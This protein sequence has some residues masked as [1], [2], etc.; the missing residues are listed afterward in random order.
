MTTY[1]LPTRP[2]TLVDSVNRMAA[3]TGSV[4]YAQMASDADYNGHHV[5]F[6][7]PN[8][9]KPYWTCHYHWGEIVT[10][11]R[12]DLD[13]CLAAAER[14]Y[15]R[16]AKAASAT[17][18]VES[19]EDIAVVEARGRWELYSQ[20]AEEAH[21]ATFKDE[22]YDLLSEAVSY[23]KHGLWMGAVG[24]L[25]NCESASE[26]VE[27]REAYFAERRA[28]AE[29]D[30]QAEAERQ[31]QEDA[32]LAVLEE[33]EAAEIAEK[34]RLPVTECWFTRTRCELKGGKV[35]QFG[36]VFAQSARGFTYQLTQDGNTTVEAHNLRQLCRKVEKA[37]KIDPKHWIRAEE[38]NR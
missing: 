14:E 37:A 21:L 19:P 1:W 9:F 7:P 35:Q 4:R 16:G 36:R 11:G 5:S 28:R 33:E 6:T 27:K 26:Y 34:G 18:S 8:K 13:R 2:Y 32:R 20:E 10:L 12:G 15:D 3:A 24:T 25:V 23:E 17:V 29:R 31:A 22:R 38:G 30:R